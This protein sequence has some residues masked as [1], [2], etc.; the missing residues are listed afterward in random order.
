MSK[1]GEDWMH[2][3]V[4]ELS[5]LFDFDAHDFEIYESLTSMV[6]DVYMD[7]SIYELTGG[8]CDSS[9]LDDYN[10]H[11]AMVVNNENS[12]IVNALND[13]GCDMMEGN[14]VEANLVLPTSIGA[15]L[16]KRSIESPPVLELKPLP[17][18]LKYVFLGNDCSLSVIISSKLSI[19]KEDKLVEVLKLHK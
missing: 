6:H 8:D 7:T 14:I 11:D 9:V 19:V 13:D 2:I 16:L 10:V 15:S 4:D 1:H 12:L 17:P 3:K 5:S 18:Y